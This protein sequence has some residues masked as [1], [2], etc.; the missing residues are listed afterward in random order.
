MITGQSLAGVQVGR[1]VVFF[2][3]EGDH[4][5]TVSF[6]VEGGRFQFL[7]TGL[8]AGTWEIWWNG[9]LVD[10]DLPARPGGTLLFEGPAGNYFLRRR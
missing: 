4:P 3:S 7:L 10:P 2:P 1:R 9:G 8:A 5:R 6:D